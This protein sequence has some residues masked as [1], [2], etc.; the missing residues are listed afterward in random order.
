MS[1]LLDVTPRLDAL[2]APWNRTD[3]PGLVVGVRTTA[4]LEYRRGFGMASLEA[5]TANTVST[6]MRIGSTTKHMLAVL[7]LTLQDRGLLRLDDA[8]GRHLPELSGVNA[9]PTIRQLLQHRGGGRCHLD[10]GFLGHGLL[11][12]PEGSALQA[13]TRQ[14]GRNFAA[15]AAMIYNNA[16]YHLV[17]RAVERLTGVA[18]ADWMT[19]E[20]FEP[21]G[22]RATALV[23]S[24]HLLTPGMATLT[25]PRGPGG[26]RRGLFPSEEILGEGGVVSTIDDMLRWASRLRAAGTAAGE[27]GW[28][29]LLDVAADAD[30]APGYYGL[31]LIVTDYR[32]VRIL[33]HPGGVVGGASDL[34]CVPEHGL[35]IVV[36]S[37]GAPGASPALLSDQIMDIVLGG[38][39]GPPAAR[40]DARAAQDWLGVYASPDSGMVYGLEAPGGDLCLRIAGYAQPV[41]LTPAGTGGFMTVVN[42]I[43]RIQLHLDGSNEQPVLR[44]RF[45]GDEERMTRLQP[46][47]SGSE[48]APEAAAGEFGSAESGLSATILREGGRVWLDMRDTWGAARFSLAPLGGQWLHVRSFPDPDLWGATLYFPDGWSAGFVLNSART[49]NLAF[50]RQHL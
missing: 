6:R 17:S 41:N 11:A 1:E 19:R 40:P 32:G 4:G 38:V 9:G 10:L 16:G 34:V 15:G 35:D 29:G 22:M 7:V 18:L 8:I 23:P 24:D 14:K 12:A 37:N 28:G 43:G 42:G 30:G 3:A 49:R 45:A 50:T 46:P 5:G 27:P 25:L 13:I 31:G 21:F 20:L 33:R 48:Q 2:F 39:A 44:L 47:A 26:W 36:L